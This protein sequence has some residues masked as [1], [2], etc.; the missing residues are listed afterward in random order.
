M[1]GL[2]PSQAIGMSVRHFQVQT[3]V[4]PTGMAVFQAPPGLSPGEHQ[5]T[6][7]LPASSAEEAARFATL[8]AEW[9]AA[10]GMHSSAA[11]RA[12]HLAYQRIIG[13]GEGAVSLILGELRD[14]GPDDWFWA[15]NAITG[16]NPITP[17]I[18]GDMRKMTEAWLQ[19]GKT[20][21]YLND[22]LP[23][24]SGISPTSPR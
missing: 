13:M 1:M 2:L 16:E 4:S 17:E 20:A 7:T 19:W 11:R 8:A 14:R 15:L 23:R 24:S 6:V 10:T 12:Q 18:A 5:V 9:R 3:T 21:G 22:S